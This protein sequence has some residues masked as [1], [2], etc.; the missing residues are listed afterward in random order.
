MAHC[1]S[2]I[3]GVGR[4]RARRVAG[5]E[6]INEQ[7]NSVP[8]YAFRD[9]STALLAFVALLKLYDNRICTVTRDT[10]KKV[11]RFALVRYAYNASP[12]RAIELAGEAAAGIEV[13]PRRGPA[14]PSHPLRTATIRAVQAIA[15]SE[16]YFR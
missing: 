12:G 11:T 7:G 14:G 4:I 6:F 15:I 13:L 16:E 9:G 2:G 1:T 8:V 10:L 3:T 5:E